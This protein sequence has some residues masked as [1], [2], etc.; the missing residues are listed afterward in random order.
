MASSGA[1][2]I[3][4]EGGGCDSLPRLEGLFGSLGGGE[5]GGVRAGVASPVIAGESTSGQR[6]VGEEG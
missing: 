6:E 3:V 4:D 2:N 5:G 1:L